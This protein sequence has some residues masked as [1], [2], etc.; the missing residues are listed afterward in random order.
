MGTF[1]STPTQLRLTNLLIFP[2]SIPLSYLSVKAFARSSMAD[3]SKSGGFWRR[4]KLEIFQGLVL[5]EY[6]S[7]DG[8][9]STRVVGLRV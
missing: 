4:P 2:V 6:S 5:G 1:S 7:Y 9:I 3:M 8:Q